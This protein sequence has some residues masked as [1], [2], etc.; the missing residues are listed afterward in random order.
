MLSFM[1]AGQGS[2]ALSTNAA[3][4]SRAGHRGLVKTGLQPGQQ[5]ASG[6]RRVHAYV[7]VGV[8]DIVGLGGDCGHR[9]L[10][11]L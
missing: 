5:A 9:S 11:V 6:L 3:P 8:R 10:G 1:V 4:D 7:E 2:E